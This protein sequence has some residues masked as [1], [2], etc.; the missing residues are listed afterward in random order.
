MKFLWFLLLWFCLPLLLYET[1]NC[2]TIELPRDQSKYKMLQ[3]QQVYFTDLYFLGKVSDSSGYDRAMD[4]TAGCYAF[5]VDCQS[6][7]DC[8]DCKAIKL[9]CNRGAPR[10]RKCVPAMV[11]IDPM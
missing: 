5:E 4:F 7:A 2:A 6:N 3:H 11:Q 10:A 9:F 1:I 8:A